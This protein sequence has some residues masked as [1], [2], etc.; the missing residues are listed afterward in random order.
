VS[1]TIDGVNLKDYLQNSK[2]D[3]NGKCSLLKDLIIVVGNLHKVGVYHCD[4]S[5]DNIMVGE[6]IKLVDFEK[7]CNY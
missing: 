6:K 1:E 2:L 5:T 7:C 4:L 3:T